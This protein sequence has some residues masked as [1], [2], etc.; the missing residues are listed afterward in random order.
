MK[1]LDLIETFKRIGREERKKTASYIHWYARQL[2]LSSFFSLFPRKRIEECHVL[3]TRENTNVTI[4]AMY[5][6]FT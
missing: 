4:K 6:A 5:T 3:N 2:T 1:N